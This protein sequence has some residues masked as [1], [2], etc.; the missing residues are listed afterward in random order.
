MRAGNN[1]V[2]SNPLNHRQQ[3]TVRLRPHSNDRVGQESVTTAKQGEV[4]TLTFL[5]SCS[6]GTPF[7]PL[8]RGA[9]EGH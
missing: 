6:I 7:G 3:S 2:W 1:I 4:M 5:S 9:A 8:C